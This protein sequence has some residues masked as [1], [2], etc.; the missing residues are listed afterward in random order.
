MA[1]FDGILKFMQLGGYLFARQDESGQQYLVSV[2][3]LQDEYHA[4]LYV[5]PKCGGLLAVWSTTGS[6]IHETVV[7][8]WDKYFYVG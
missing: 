2:V 1:T 4:V 8:V 5:V 6:T 3:T 7:E